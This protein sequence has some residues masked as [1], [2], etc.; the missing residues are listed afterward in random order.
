MGVLIGVSTAARNWLAKTIKIG[1]KLDKRQQTHPCRRARR[2]GRRPTRH[3][4]TTRGPPRQPRAGRQYQARPRPHRTAD[5]S[6]RRARTAGHGNS[7]PRTCPRPAQWRVQPGRGNHRRL[8]LQPSPR[9]PAIPRQRPPMAGA[10]SSPCANRHAHTCP[11]AHPDCPGPSIDRRV[12]HVERGFGR[13]RRFG[14]RA[15]H[16][17]RRT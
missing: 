9:T 3:R 13:A 2:P 11:D 5:S 15:A 8:P 1:S 12:R 7:H 14:R 10:Y 16:L 4:R 6:H 17:G